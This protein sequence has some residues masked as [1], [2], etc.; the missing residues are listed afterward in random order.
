MAARSLA[1][2]KVSLSISATVRNMLE[3]G[4]YATSA[5]THTVNKTLS[6]GV[7]AGQANRG[8]HYRSTLTAAASID[9]DLYDFAAIDIGAG[10]GNDGVGQTMS[11]TEE[12][13]AIVIVNENAQNAG[14]TLEIEP[15]ASNGWSPIGTHTDAT[16]GSLGGQ[17]VLAKWDY[18]EKGFDI[19]DA[20]SH[21]I[22]LTAKTADV[23]YGIYILGRHDDEESSSSSSESSSSSSTSSSSSS[24]TS[25][26][27]ASST[28][29]SSESSS[30][31]SSSSSSS[32]S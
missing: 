10:A 29:S 6:S 9:I 18:S 17:G 1:Q 23:A 19:T 31:S 28:S 3:D 21:R 20:S 4:T 8:W 24:S 15:S 16:G 22:K 7:S 26:S 27:S 12:V 32:Q 13:A 5:M 11:P 25:S 2:P 14:G 30:F